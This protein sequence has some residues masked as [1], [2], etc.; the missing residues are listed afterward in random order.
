[1]D[2]RSQVIRDVRECSRKRRP[3][4]EFPAVTITLAKRKGTN[5]SVLAEQ[6]LSKVDSL[7]GYLIRKT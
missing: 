2:Q 1:M 6:V 5:A 7:H 4:E 3:G